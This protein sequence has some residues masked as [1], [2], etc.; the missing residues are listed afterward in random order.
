MRLD[1]ALSRFEVQLRADGRSPHTIGQYRRAIGLLGRWL[2]AAGHGTALDAITPEV[3]AAFLVSP[4]V[5]TSARGGA[6]AA[7]SVNATRTG[8]R[9]F[10]GWVHEAGYSASNPARLIRR[11]LCA[12]PPPRALSQAE[13][14]RLLQALDAASGCSA[15]R[16]RVLVRLLLATGVRLGSA[17]A[18]DAEDVDLALG[19]LTLRS[20]KGDRVERIPLGREIR[21][22]LAGYLALRPRRGPLFRNPRG[23]RL[24]KRQA[25][26]QITRW[27]DRVGIEN[28]TPHSL[29]HSFATGLLARTGDLFLVKQALR[30]RSIASTTVYLSIDDD[31]LRQALQ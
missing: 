18:L 12:P 10:F 26:R 1:E 23:E 21:D 11:G 29:R 6:K 17:I 27:L 3:L 15:R 16:D 8:L 7:I 20:V 22:H 25:Q 4:E 30:H 28:G 24:S 13:V 19:Q 14:D 2:A 31:R 9:V 5:R